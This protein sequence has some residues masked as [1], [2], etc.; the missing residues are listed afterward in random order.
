MR[1]RSQ[2]IA[3]IFI[4]IAL[5]VVIFLFRLHRAE[6]LTAPPENR[7]AQTN[8]D[9]TPRA[10]WPGQSFRQV[11]MPPASTSTATTH[12]AESGAAEGAE[13]AEAEDGSDRDRIANE[14]LFT[15]YDENDRDAFL[16]L[17]ERL[18]VTVLG[19]MELGHAVRLRVPSRAVLQRLLTEGPPP[20]AHGANYHVRVPRTVEPDDPRAPRSDYVGFGDKMLAWLGVSGDHSTWGQGITVAVLDTGVG[21]HSAISEEQIRRLNLVDDSG[22]AGSHA[23]SVASLLIG[24]SDSVTGLSPGVDVL[25]IRVMPEGERG[26]AFTLASAIV[27]AVDQGSAVINISLGSYG[28]SF[29]LK[30]AIDY[31]SHNGVAVVASAG[32]DAVSDITYPAAYEDVIAV[33]AVDGTGRHIYFSNRGEE[34]D[35]AAPGLAVNAAGPDDTTIAFSG[36]SA[37]TPLVAGTIATLMASDP[38]LTAADAAEI[39]LAYTDDHGM[40]GTD[41]EYGVGTLNVGRIAARDVAGLYDVAVGDAVVTTDGDGYRLTLYVQNRGTEPLRSVDMTVTIDG[42][43]SLASLSNLDVGESAA[44]TYDLVGENLTSFGQVS[45]SYEADISDH[46]DVVPANNAA[47]GAVTLSTE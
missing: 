22:I 32:N 12:A 30:E 23:T 18:G 6:Q 14:Y 43:T 37:A 10:V 34:L 41:V 15:F 3:A 20:L 8:R 26:D 36:T 44:R 47:A 33:G 38:E 45:V 1:T 42:V 31:A 16:A 21:A 17:A 2:I 5:G 29:L 24:S 28:D 40:P 46:D 13:V 4:G 27:E 35:L 25:S 7:P 39:A 9:P 19:R 11:D